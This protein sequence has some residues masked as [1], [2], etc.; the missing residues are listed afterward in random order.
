MPSNRSP[1]QLATVQVILDEKEG[2]VYAPDIFGKDATLRAFV[3]HLNAK[4]P[5][6][7][8][9]RYKLITSRVLNTS[10][11]GAM[12]NPLDR[13]LRS[14]TKKNAATVLPEVWVQMRRDPNPP[15]IDFQYRAKLS[16][17][18][19]RYMGHVAS[20]LAARASSSMW[21]AR[22]FL[23]ATMMAE[24]GM[25][26][27]W[28]ESFFGQISLGGGKN[29][30]LADRYGQV[31]VPLVAE[32]EGHSFEE[33]QTVYRGLKVHPSVAY[34]MLERHTLGTDGV[35]TTEYF[36][37]S[38]DVEPEKFDPWSTSN[39]NSEEASGR[40]AETLREE[41]SAYEKDDILKFASDNDITLPAG[42]KGGAWSTIRRIWI[43]EI[44]AAMISRTE[45]GAK[46][47]AQSDYELL[48]NMTARE[49]EDFAAMRGVALSPK[50]NGR[51]QMN[52]WVAEIMRGRYG[53]NWAEL[54]GEYAPDR[55]IEEAIAEEDVATVAEDHEAAERVA[56]GGV[57]AALAAISGGSK[58]KK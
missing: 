17:V 31:K 41:L 16:G 51:P 48:Q 22:E 2:V 20:T 21:A 38:D 54:L 13:E 18:F 14:W 15:Q 46:D 55:E 8:P 34:G 6:T 23:I 27:L 42:K 44:V 5:K 7:S 24:A 33:W 45:A 26:V 47:A 39:T 43:E 19:I 12:T 29:A 35:V 28:T 10:A 58:A 36:L 56:S 11:V 52:V 32:G 9:P 57:T 53:A 4:S 1:Q 37:G 25:T 3:E 30:I 49:I 50:K 40:Y